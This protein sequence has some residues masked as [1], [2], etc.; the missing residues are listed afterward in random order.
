MSGS[1]PKTFSGAEIIEDRFDLRG[2]R[3][4]RAHRLAPRVRNLLAPWRSIF[5]Q[6]GIGRRLRAAILPGREGCCPFKKHYVHRHEK[7]DVSFRGRRIA[8]HWDLLLGLRCRSERR[9]ALS[10]LLR[11][12]IVLI[13]EELLHPLVVLVHLPLPRPAEAHGPSAFCTLLYKRVTRPSVSEHHR[14]LLGTLVLNPPKEWT[15]NCRRN[16]W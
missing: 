1:G 8:H 7:H 6:H 16:A 14:A 2:R 13:A 4:S 11:E 12:A 10:E 9:P 15:G 5:H 3:S